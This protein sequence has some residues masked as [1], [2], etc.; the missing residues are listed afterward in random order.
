MITYARSKSNIPVLL[1]ILYPSGQAKNCNVCISIGEWGISY[2]R[3]T[4][5]SMDVKIYSR[6]ALCRVR[7]KETDRQTQ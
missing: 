6:C 7:L 2:S 3:H 4:N 1:F 5:I